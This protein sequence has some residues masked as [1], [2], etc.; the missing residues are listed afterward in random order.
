SD[1]GSCSI[2]QPNF[3][4]QLS[5]TNVIFRIPTPLFGL[6]LVENVPD[7]DQDMTIGLEA[8][9]HAQDNLAISL[10]IGGHVNRSGNDGTIMRFGWKAQNKSLLIFA[11]EAYNVEQGV[12]N[13][14]FPNERDDTANC[15]INALPEDHTNLVNTDNTASPASDFSS[16]TVN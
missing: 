16:D 3:A 1:A 6:G 9:F 8:A 14:L 5:N 2:A 12:T 7:G 11:G 15:R 13:E 10:G 4:S